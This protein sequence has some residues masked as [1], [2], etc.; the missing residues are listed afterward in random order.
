MAATILKL[1]AEEI[2][3]KFEWVQ[4]DGCDTLL[5]HLPGYLKE[6]LKV[7]VTT[8]RNLRVLGERKINERKLTRFQKEFSLADDCDVNGITAKFDGGVLQ[9][10]LP[11]MAG[12]AM[13]EEAKS[14]GKTEDEKTTHDK[15]DT[16]LNKT[17]ETVQDEGKKVD[18]KMEG[19]AEVGKETGGLGKLDTKE[20]YQKMGLGKMTRKK[21]TVLTVVIV[22]V[23]VAFG[24][25]MLQSNGSIHKMI[26]DMWG[27][28]RNPSQNVS[29]I[30]STC[31][32]P[33]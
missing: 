27:V 29:V 21:A 28:T 11:K 26:N 13:Q 17:Q 4:R 23:A 31:C 14:A 3:P 6:N 33:M 22:G 24:L 5:V 30:S 7:Q 1:H 16:Q 18:E 32:C 8:S 25:Q 15:A 19:A 20:K 9:V 10:R 12:L 2:E